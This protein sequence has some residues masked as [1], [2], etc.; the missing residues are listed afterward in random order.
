MIEELEVALHALGR[1][2]PL[3]HSEADF[4]HALAWAF[5]HLRP[6]VTV[7]LEVPSRFGDRRASVDIIL[8]D[9]D[10]TCFV[11]LK[12]KTALVEATEGGEIFALKNHGAKDLGSYDVIKDVCRVESFVKA[13]P[14]SA[15]CV[16]FIT[17]APSY[18]N[19]S[20]R[21]NTID[22]D[23]Q[24]VDGREI[25][26]DLKWASHAGSGSV[27]KREHVLSLNGRYQLVWKPYSQVSGVGATTFRYL[28]FKMR[29]EEAVSRKADI[30][31]Q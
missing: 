16:I 6:D 3:F 12:Y 27:K 24:L 4:Q 9:G 25:S 19:A 20:L 13:V 7:R 10:R 21:S 28:F 2:R 29:K 18:W 31:G 23:F 14:N 17:N 8:R 5:H 30:E 1:S 11:E 15:G 26:G 22:K